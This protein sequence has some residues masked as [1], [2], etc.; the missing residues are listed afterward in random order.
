MIEQYLTSPD[1]QLRYL[2]EIRNKKRGVIG[3]FSSYVP[4]E[5]ILATGF[6]PY[7]FFSSTGIIGPSLSSI[8]GPCC[9]FAKKIAK[10]TLHKSGLVDGMVFASF[11]DSMKNLNKFLSKD[12][13]S[14]FM[15]TIFI[16]AVISGDS[17]NYFKESLQEFMSSLSKY[18]EIRLD[19]EM[20]RQSVFATERNR[21]LL[22][23][24]S[25]SRMTADPKISG[26][27][28]VKMCVLN[29][30]LDKELVYEYICQILHEGKT[31][32][33]NIAQQRRIMVVG[34]TIDTFQFLEEIEKLD[35]F[36]ACEEFMNET[37]YINIR[38][39]QNSD[40]IMFDISKA[41][42]EGIVNLVV[43]PYYSRAEWITS[44]IEKYNIGGV[45]FIT[46]TSCE[47]YGF[48]YVTLKKI[49]SKKGIPCM[50]LELES[51]RPPYQREILRMR[52][53][54]DTLSN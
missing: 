31:Y 4:E 42:L 14:K 9:S 17:I 12:L 53:F 39:N 27:E 1:L 10:T 19:E 48:S 45:L 24:L 15:K 41:Y 29:K 47:P 43:Y 13:E 37:G 7:Q 5:I 35:V 50:F 44:K 34:P 6:H 51:T 33:S 52:W 46:M 18:F 11:C 20:I 21:E 26:S 54:L 23:K 38:I 22:R 16:P 25:E 30:L 2:Q 49:L 3:Y 8:I 36:I 40:D 32:T 28:I